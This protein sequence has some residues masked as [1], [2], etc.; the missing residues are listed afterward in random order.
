MYAEINDVIGSDQL[1]Q[2][3]DQ[4]NLP[5]TTAVISEIQRISDIG[6][7]VLR[8]VLED[9]TLHGYDIPKSATVVMNLNSVHH[10][11]EV[12]PNPL[13]FQP[14][15]FLDEHGKYKSR[16]EFMPFSM[17]EYSIEEYPE[18]F[19]LTVTDPQQ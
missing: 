5:Y 2:M 9:T 13:V 19:M 4:P 18:Q 12:W 11:P 8:A 6:P 14:E 17:G 1:P 10:D 16:S 15:R 7:F 3:S